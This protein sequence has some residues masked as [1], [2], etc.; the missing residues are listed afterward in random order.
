MLIGAVERLECHVAL[1]LRIPVHVAKS[2]RLWVTRRQILK[3][4]LCK[5][6]RK[7]VNPLHR[8]Q[9]FANFRS[10]PRST[11]A[12]IRIMKNRSSPPKTLFSGA[13]VSGIYKCAYSLAT[14]STS[15]ISRANEPQLVSRTPPT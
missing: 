9:S 4:D 11:R 6:I 12:C 15:D 7:P 8:N 14:W 5:F 3:T 10:L 1:Q 2:C 13:H